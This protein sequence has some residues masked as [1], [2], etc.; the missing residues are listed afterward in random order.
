MFGLLPEVI[1]LAA[2]YSYDALNFALCFLAISYF[3]YMIHGGKQV[4]VGNLLIF[5]GVVLIMIPIKLVYAPLLG[6][7]F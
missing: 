7:V 6:L 2:S 1:Y 4:K 3:F 5:L